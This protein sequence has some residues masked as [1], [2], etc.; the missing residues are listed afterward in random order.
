MDQEKEKPKKFLTPMERMQKAKAECNERDY[1]KAKADFEH[2]NIIMDS[3]PPNKMS[4]DEHRKAEFGEQ[5]EVTKEEYLEMI[6]NVMAGKIDG[7]EMEMVTIVLEVPRFIDVGVTFQSK[8][9]SVTKEVLYGH[10]L[11]MGMEADALM[12]LRLMKQR[13]G[14]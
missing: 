3:K 12:L 4:Y 8:R 14:F 2:E 10:Y 9:D 7:P 13:E 1:E 11:K 6:T 5:K